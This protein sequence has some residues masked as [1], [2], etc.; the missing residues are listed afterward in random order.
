MG[1]GSRIDWLRR[2]GAKPATWNPV[3]GCTPESPGCANCYA[4]RSA[5]R[6]SEE[7]QP[8]HGL[9]E[10][11]PKG[12]KWTGEVRTV[13][14]ML[15]KPL[16]WKKPRMIFVNS[17]SDLFHKDVP[18]RFIAAVFG[19]IAASPQ[20]TFQVLTKR[21]SRALEWLEELHESAELRKLAPQA[22]CVLELE[23]V[24]HDLGESK[25]KPDYDRKAWPLPNLWFGAS[26]E[27]QRQLDKRVK[28]LFLF[29]AAVRW[30][31]LEPL[32]DGVHVSDH[33]PHPASCRCG[34]CYRR[35]HH[36]SDPLVDWVVV[37]GESGPGARPF[38]PDW[39]R[40]LVTECKI[41]GTPLFV[42][43]LG[44]NPIGVHLNMRNTNLLSHTDNIK[45]I[46][47]HRW[48]STSN[49]NRL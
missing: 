7:G 48:F 6:L 32:L 16:R 18:S 15:T 22:R 1:D 42:K 35:A 28:D 14:S 4:P 34:E 10:S 29:D 26:G 21:M 43:Q 12:P 39:A 33:L 47:T 13:P 31:S 25:L 2:A 45:Q 23:T 49:L 19:V 17:M 27:N 24:L 38:D 37:G 20:H 46:I 8:Y 3:R 44:S 11:T 9:V 40:Q 5:I 36:P 41:A 30:L